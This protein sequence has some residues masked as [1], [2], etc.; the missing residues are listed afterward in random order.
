MERFCYEQFA[1]FRS[2]G[3]GRVDQVHTEFNCA[4]ENFKRVGPVR[5]PSP[6]SVPGDPHRAK[7]EPVDRQIAA[8]LPDRIRDHSRCCRGISSEYCT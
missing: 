7:A 4:P 6:N 8:Q 2:V 1:C 3:I 5:R